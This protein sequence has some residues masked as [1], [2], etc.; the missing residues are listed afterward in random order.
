M[1]RSGEK[2]LIIMAF[3]LSIASV[4]MITSRRALLTRIWFCVDGVSEEF[5]E[6]EMEV[7]VPG[8]SKTRQR[9]EN[10]GTNNFFKTELISGIWQ[11]YKTTFQIGGFRSGISPTTF[12]KITDWLMN[13]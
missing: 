8:E 3:V 5:H 13:S 4:G 2:M 11:I 10:V 12:S 7:R 1:D 6:G 9:S